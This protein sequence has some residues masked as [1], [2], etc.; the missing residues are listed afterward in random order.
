MGKFSRGIIPNAIFLV[1]SKFMFYDSSFRILRYLCSFFVSFLRRIHTSCP[2]SLRSFVQAHLAITYD[3]NVVTHYL[4]GINVGILVCGNN[5]E[6]F[7]LLEVSKSNAKWTIG[8][9]MF[10]GKMDSIYV[11]NRI[12]PVSSIQTLSFNNHRHETSSQLL[13]SRKPSHAQSVHRPSAPPMSANSGMS[14]AVTFPNA[15]SKF[16]YLFAPDTLLIGNLRVLSSQHEVSDPH[17]LKNDNATTVI[18][19]FSLCPSIATIAMETE[20]V[21]GASTYNE[22]VESNKQSREK[23]IKVTKHVPTMNTTVLAKNVRLKSGYN[24]ISVR[25]PFWVSNGSHVIN[26]ISGPNFATSTVTVKRTS[27][28]TPTAANTRGYIIGDIREM[29]KSTFTNYAFD[30]KGYVCAKNYVGTARTTV[31]SVP[32]QVFTLEGCYA[33][34]VMPNLSSILGYSDTWPS[35]NEKEDGSVASTALEKSNAVS[36]S[37]PGGGL[38]GGRSATKAI[39]SSRYGNL[40]IVGFQPQ[41]VSCDQDF[42][43]TVKYDVCRGADRSVHFHGCQDYCD[44][45]TTNLTGYNITN[46]YG[47][48]QID[49]FKPKGVTCSDGFVGEP[50][51]HSCK[52]HQKYFTMTGCVNTCTTI[53]DSTGYNRTNVEEHDLHYATFNVSKWECDNHYVGEPTV[54]IC[55]GS[56]S[57]LNE[58]TLT[59][60]KSR[61]RAPDKHLGYSQ[62]HTIETS[63]LVGQTDATRFDVTGWGCDY[64]FVGTA[65]ATTCSGKDDQYVM[66]GCRNTCDMTSIPK[67]GTIGDCTDN[68]PSGKTCQ[69]TCRKGY[70]N[71]HDGWRSCL[72]GISMD[73]FACNGK[74]CFDTD[75]I[76]ELTNGTLGTCG[77]Y[78]LETVISA[79]E[80]GVGM[81]Q[82]A[83]NSTVVVTLK[84]PL[85]HGDS[86][87]P[88]CD[89]GFTPEGTR[90]CMAGELIN[91]FKCVPVTCDATMVPEHGNTGDCSVHLAAGRTCQPTCQEGYENKLG[92]VR[93]C[94]N[95]GILLDTFQCTGKPCYDAAIVAELANG[96]LGTCGRYRLQK[97]EELVS[98]PQAQAENNSTL[99]LFTQDSGVLLLQEP[100]VHGDSCVPTCDP[101]YTP[102][103]TRSCMA[104]DFADT[105]TC[106]PMTCDA[107]SIPDHGTQGDCTPTLV[108]GE[109]CT[110]TCHE[111]YINVSSLDVNNNS[112]GILSR[113][114]HFAVRSCIAGSLVDTFTCVAA[115]CT[116]ADNMTVWQQKSGGSCPNT[117]L[118]EVL[119]S[120]QSCIPEC[121]IGLVPFGGRMCQAGKIEDT[122]TCLV[123]WHAAFASIGAGLLICCL[124]FSCMFFCR[125]TGCCCGCAN[126]CAPGGAG[127]N[128]PSK[129]KVTPRPPSE[130]SIM[131]KKHENEDANISA[132]VAQK[133]EKHKRHTQERVEK[134]RRASIDAGAQKEAAAAKAAELRAAREKLQEAMSTGDATKIQTA[135]DDV[136]NDPDHVKQA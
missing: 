98:E 91:T 46:I 107:S 101:G 61:C 45:P 123:P 125:K 38:R 133:Q 129:T 4:N 80:G 116:N 95:D 67:H 14:L 106:S 54:H 77:R 56:T 27:C 127:G 87:I 71:Q 122:F 85:L 58:Y 49:N 40:S 32:T 100:L 25:I 19:I 78:R 70:E 34:C 63:L 24:S 51:F 108:S 65:K 135:L 60:C 126:D 16:S 74:P 57:Q 22:V 50:I 2:L 86:C 102:S 59:G 131:V 79:V 64:G 66:S 81:N 48:M 128:N 112:T 29:S 17:L 119:P 120:G 130:P 93:A 76:S 109:M 26:I 96:T 89:A 47:S 43:G 92:G 23:D 69:P 114:E 31:C 115:S 53:Q 104:G 21:N 121:E 42:V 37:N 75:I 55:T 3:G 9:G 84:E 35:S 11:Y 90:S 1:Q 39:V 33:T 88:V 134:R 28:A 44:I 30:V 20:V 113:R 8:S 6:N 111:G 68:L 110:P 12:I 18:D 7:R 13:N 73:T 97:K 5:L 41:N 136:E 117:T 83:M 10:A 118:G 52:N 94:M 103:G 36:N 82:T 72:N 15:P 62:E 105:F 99:S 124:I 132:Q